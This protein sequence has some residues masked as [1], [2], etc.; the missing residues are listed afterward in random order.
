MYTHTHAHPHPNSH[1]HAHPV[2]LQ[3]QGHSVLPEVTTGGLRGS[4]LC[5]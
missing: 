4:E 1:T 5:G 2:R 3:Q